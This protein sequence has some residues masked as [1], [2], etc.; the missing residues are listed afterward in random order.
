M[1]WLR[2]LV[3]GVGEVLGIDELNIS[4]SNTIL[5]EMLW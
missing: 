3:S 4:G 5:H 1:G 2:D